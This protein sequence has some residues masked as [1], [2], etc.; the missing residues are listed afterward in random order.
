MVVSVQCLTTSVDMMINIL[1]KLL[2]TGTVAAKVDTE[3]VLSGVP[4]GSKAC[5]VNHIKDMVH[6]HR[7]VT[8]NIQ[9]LQQTLVRSHSSTPHLVG[10][11]L[12]R[13]V[14]V[15]MDALGRHNR[16]NILS[17]I[18]ALVLPITVAYLTCLGVLSQPIRG[19]TQGSAPTL[20][21]N[22]AAT[23]THF[24]TMVNRRKY[25]VVLV[26]LWASLEDVPDLLQM[27]QVRQD[28]HN[29]KHKVK[30]RVNKVTVDTW[31]TRC[32][33]SRPRSTVEALEA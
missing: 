24:A 22:K 14:L 15:V 28:C 18:P 27:C 23:M 1:H 6:P 21:A 16:R 33:V 17:S 30:V 8:T 10:I 12:L 29:L 25:L 5:M 20:A 31:A 9:P 32:M 3:E 19:R 26:L 4:E 13:E 11:A 2:S 7:R